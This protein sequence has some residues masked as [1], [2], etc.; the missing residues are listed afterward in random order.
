MLF[1]KLALLLCHLMTALVTCE[2]TPHGS[3]SLAALNVG[4]NELA[5]VE[6]YHQL[7]IPVPECYKLQHKIL[8]QVGSQS[9]ADKTK[10]NIKGLLWCHFEMFNWIDTFVPEGS[11]GSVKEAMN[12]DNC[13]TSEGELFGGYF[14]EFA[15]DVDRHL[16]FDTLL[17]F[18]HEVYDTAHRRHK[19]HEEEAVAL[20]QSLDSLPAISLCCLVYHG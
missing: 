11:C 12:R 7:S 3:S 10:R 15:L 9:D 5:N 16:V 2:A 19:E 8:S 17:T 1:A 18:V 6:K 4:N 14:D 13:F 20:E